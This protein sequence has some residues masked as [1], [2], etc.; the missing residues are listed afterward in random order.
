MKKFIL[1][2]MAITV[3]LFALSATLFSQSTIYGFVRSGPGGTPIVG[4]TIN[5]KGTPTV[6]ITDDNGNY[7]IEV[8]S[9]VPVTLTATYPGYSPS[10]K[11]L[12]PDPGLNNW[13]NFWFNPP[14]L[15]SDFDG[16]YYNTVAIGTQTW[17]A[18]NLLVT[19]YQDGTNIPYVTD[20]AAWAALISPGYCWYNNDAAANKATYGALYNWYTINTSKLC[21]IGWHAPSEYEWRTLENYLIANGYN[22]DGSTAG[23]NIAK[24]LA[25]IT[26]WAYSNG[27]GT[28]GATDYPAYRNKS[29]FTA[30][31]GGCRTFDI[32][33]FSSISTSG[34]WWTSTQEF[35]TRADY[36]QLSSNLTGTF[37][38]FTDLKMGFSVRCVNDPPS[39]TISGTTSVCKDAA[40]P[41][42]TFTGISGTAPYTFTYKINN[43]SPLTVTTS[44]GNSVTVSVPTNT[45]GTFT[46]SLTN[47]Q[48]AYAQVSETGNAIISINP[49]PSATINGTTSVCQNGPFPNITFT[50][51]NGAA[52]Y[53]FTYNINNGS[54]QTISTNSGNSITLAAPTSSAG[55]FIYTLVSVRDASVSAC[56]QLQPGTSTITIHP[57][58]DVSA[59]ITN[60]SC[61]QCK[62]GAIVLTPTTG[63]PPFTFSWSGPSGFS[64]NSK[65]LSKLKPGTYNLTISDANDCSGTYS[66]TIISPFIVTNVND[67]GDGSFRNALSKANESHTITPDTI[68]FNI[69]GTGPFV[70]QPLTPLPEITDPVVIDG[71]S[72][73]GASEATRT[74]PARLM[75]VLNGSHP[76]SG[77]L[78]I[79]CGGSTIKGLTINYFSQGISLYQNGAN[80]IVGNHIGTNPDGSASVLNARGI[81]LVSSDNIIGGTTA[82]ERNIISGNSEWGMEILGGTGNIIQGNYIGLSAD[83]SQAI[84]NNIGGILI[85]ASNN[86]IGGSDPGAGNVISGNG[87]DGI[88]IGDSYYYGNL[89]VGNLIGTDVTGKNA[90]GNVN[91]G[92]SINGADSNIVGGVTQNT[93]NLISGNQ[94]GILMTS[95]RLNMVIGNLIGTDITGTSSVGNQD[96]IVVTFEKNIIGGSDLGEG[97]IISGNTDIGIFLN[98]TASNNEV[99]GNYVGTDISGV[100]KLPNNIGISIHRAKEN[101]IGGTKPGEGNLISGN[102]AEGILIHDSGSTPSQFPTD[103][104]KVVSNY[105]GTDI[106]GSEPLGNGTY[107]IRFGNFAHNNTI[108]GLDYNAGNIIAFNGNSGITFE[109]ALL[110]CFGNSIISNSIFSNGG[111]GIDLGD[112]GAN[113][114][115]N[116]PVLDSVELDLGK[117]TVFITGRLESTADRIF[118]LQFFASKVGDS[119]GYGEGEN[120]LGSDSV[121]TNSDG[122]ASFS[123]TFDIS[124]SWGDVISATATDTQD[125]TSEFS[126]YIGGFQ[127]QIIAVNNWPFY[128]KTNSSGILRITDGS[129]IVAVDSSFRTWTRIPTAKIDFRNGGTTTVKNASATDGINLVTFIDETFPF[130]PGVL[131]VAAKTLKVVPGSNVARIID[132]DIVVNPAFARNDVGVGY[133]NPNQGT[134]DI[135][136][137]ITHEIGHVLGLVHSGV[138]NSTMFYR[139]DVGTK[140]RSLEVDD[141]SWAGY[142]YPGTTYNSTYGSISGKITYAYDLQPVAGALVLAINTVTRDT[143]HAYSDAD[144]NYLVPGLRA[145]IYNVYIE[146]LDGSPKVFNLKPG[147]ISSYIYSNTAYTDY[148]GE[149][150]S[151][152]ESNVEVTDIPKPV[153]VTAGTETQNINLITN[154]DL[155]QPKILSVYP[156]NAAANVSVTSD[157]VITFSKPIDETTLTD[158]T[159]YLESGGIKHGVKYIPVG[160]ST[161]IILVAIDSALKYGATYNIHVTKEVNDLK[162]NTLE[163]I[164]QSNFATANP[165]LTIPE[166]T[167]TYPT[168]EADSVY[169]MEKIIVF[170]SKPM[171]RS[172]VENSFTLTWAEGTPAVIKKVDGS[173]NWD[174]ENKTVSFIPATSLKEGTVYTVKVTL[175]A[176][177]LAGNHMTVDKSFTFTTVLTAPP[178]I[179]YL[180]PGDNSAN[181]ATTTPIV[182]DFSEPIDPASVTIS[183]FKL[184]LNNTQV[185]G[186]FDFLNENSRVVFT[187]DADLGFGQSCTI[188]LTTGIQD[189][190]V[191]ISEHLA[192]DISSTFVTATQPTVPHIY[193][194]EPPAG[195]ILAEIIITGYGFDPNPVNNTVK[196][197]GIS[198]A[199]TAATLTTLTTKVPVGAVS[200]MVT[201]TGRNNLPADNSYYFPVTPQSDNPCESIVASAPAGSKTKDVAVSPDNAFAYVTNPLNDEVTVIDLVSSKL[202]TSIP[203]GTTPMK[204]DINPLGTLAYV[205]N[206]NSNDVSVIKLATKSVIKTIKVGIHP[207]GVVV[208]PDGKCVYI[209]NYFSENLS[210]IDTDPNSGGY[211]KVVANVPTGT[212]TSNVTVTPDGMMVLVTGDFGLKIVDTNPK[213]ANYNNVVANVSSGT[214]TRDV[215]VTPDGAL[216][217]VSTEEGNLLVIDLHPENGD[218]SDAVVANVPAGTKISNVKASGDN[219][220]V[221]VT[222][223]DNNEILVFKLTQG[224]TSL[225]NAVSGSGISLVQHSTIAVGAGPEGL[226]ITS[227]ADKLYFIDGPTGSR[228]V[229]TM[230]LCCGPV[231]PAKAIGDLIT[232]VQNMINAGYISASNGKDLIDKLNKALSD[233]QNKK[234]KNLI[235]DLNAFTNKVQSLINGH[236]LR[237][238]LGQPLIDGANTLI[239]QLKGLK[240]ATTGFN[241]IKT[242]AVDE[243][244]VTESKLG[245]IYPNPSNG[246]FTINYEVADNYEQYS[247]VLIW[248]YDIYGGIVSKLVDRTMETGRYTVEWNGKY[249]N[250]TN[251]PAGTYFVHF[252]TRSTGN[253]RKIVL[254]R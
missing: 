136:S 16:N 98:D 213:D 17:M 244:P 114:L 67:N 166:I 192:A 90:I 122:K 4:A 250:G 42:I 94:V 10:E 138:Y 117:K 190:S 54:N 44:S 53:T 49:I 150:Y 126:A 24:S 191:P 92:I 221:Y 153:T 236:K 20:D 157:I 173:F 11:T 86:I 34:Y 35:P 29:G 185:P 158:K 58:P 239:S 237:D 62:D 88:H 180:G 116:F 169:V 156:A 127:N 73:P 12:T 246:S 232:S 6:A 208:M 129:D 195:S 220:F 112:A 97:N 57:V 26:N 101:I 102:Q 108:G 110:P 143:V 222:A 223:T 140:V 32:G 243:D 31:P 201:I 59:L 78:Y 154:K 84:K 241:L 148:P 152:P 107:G 39:A 89:I 25:A 121:V 160:S 43:G 118:I 103:S 196:F 198:A 168:D 113:N 231:D 63:N 71:Y 219:L 9:G 14:A 95:A 19:H 251:A 177:D 115:Q 2:I 64:S 147:N 209:A 68:T 225:I 204:I 235:N 130:A 106:S 238:S 146:P 228:K 36:R 52:P 30:L 189:A 7:F 27:I 216:A 199:I 13:M 145:G 41:E 46:Y 175:A 93:K 61:N 139:L 51:A 56:S 124:S 75:I 151:D 245:L 247:N 181:I 83:G 165:D 104:N 249:D 47:V 183:S 242:I 170:F 178:A 72:Q 193:S 252:R 215:T 144:G 99:K 132:A 179:I 76:G 212:K 55:T 207:Y 172:S 240:S 186:K 206:Y 82:R 133:N 211:D 81:V 141:K 15:P 66:Y 167:S 111:L 48:D 28:P 18:E 87:G 135:Q 120:Y 230:A 60:V 218:Y 80:K 155:T 5:I 184:S 214:K 38:N 194:L 23:N 105:I 161:N 37:S 200:G 205:T 1:N 131:A 176:T 224:G 164:F 229:N 233:L 226:V 50:G 203:V 163:T 248:V 33:T 65:D 142:K 22:Y 197:N 171:N 253:V 149:F 69:A 3:L 109:G 77:G 91:A 100:K 174:S 182:A 21:P 119:T 85:S 217:I 45:I 202:V 210:L 188:T 234:T 254:I 40:Q 96:G 125:N 137:L 8:A 128:Y 187:P 162:G 79:T 70:I 123:K 159:C 74:T 227:Q 134:Y